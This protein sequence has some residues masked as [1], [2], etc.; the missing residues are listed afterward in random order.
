MVDP[1]DDLR[2]AL[3]GRY[4]ILSEIGRGGMATVYLAEDARHAR[5]V[6]VKVLKPDLAMAVGPERFLREIRITARLNHPHILPLL[7]SGEA[8]GILFY[9]MPHVTG[10]SLRR[11]LV[12]GPPLPPPEA[13]RIV[14]QAGAAL[15]HAHGQGVIH[16]DVKP[17]NILFSDG[18]AIVADFGIAKAMSAASLEV[19]TRSGFPL[20]TP[21]YMSPEQA[22][23]STV[24]DPRTWPMRCWW[25]RRPACGRRPMKCNWAGSARFSQVRA[26]DL[27]D[28]RVAW[29]RCWY[30]ASRC[31]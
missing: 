31:G 4:E 28:C 22:A 10:G 18:H 8:H 2:R 13:G 25:A 17:E 6:A 19:L 12:D 1:T 5:Q 27:T 26:R 20:G 21:G 16:R 3:A 7:D 23:G 15:E 11:R 30:V 24:Q 9:V 29:S 14:E